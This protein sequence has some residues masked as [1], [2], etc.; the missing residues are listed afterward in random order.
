MTTTSRWLIAGCLAFCLIACEQQPAPPSGEQLRVTHVP[1]G[2]TFSGTNEA[3]ERVRVRLLGI[4]APEVAHNGTPDECGAVE[5]RD[6]LQA[7][8]L[9]ADI[10][11]TDDPQ[12]DRLDRY[13]R[14]LAYVD[15]AGVDAA[16]HQ[17]Q[18]G[19]AEAWYPRSEPRPRRH[20]TYKQAERVAQESRKGA[21]TSCRH[22]GR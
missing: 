9:H 17:I 10:T 22:L 6:S 13:G 5:A 16:L 14:R 8:I 3:G 18:G 15:V 20:Q 19:Q 1:D 2:D 21:W 7:L 12:A 11:L 4:D